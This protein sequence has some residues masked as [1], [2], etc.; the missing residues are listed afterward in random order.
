M[1][2]SKAVRVCPVHRWQR[3][4]VIVTGPDWAKKE[5]QTGEG[6]ETKQ[7]R[8]S[9]D[10]NTVEHTGAPLLGKKRETTR[11]ERP[12]SKDNQHAA[13]DNLNAAHSNRHSATEDDVGNKGETRAELQLR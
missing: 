11:E 6:K 1:L 3:S 10:H 12:E 4:T 7:E 13:E 9:L 8:P 2:L 5:R